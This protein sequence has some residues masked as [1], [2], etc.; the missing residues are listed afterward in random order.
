MRRARRRRRRRRRILRLVIPTDARD[1]HP[2]PQ[3]S[4]HSF[5]RQ[6]AESVLFHIVEKT[7]LFLRVLGNRWFSRRS[8]ARVVV[9]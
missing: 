9:S 5:E 3:P 7:I 6:S 4:M 2:Q 1:N 8:G